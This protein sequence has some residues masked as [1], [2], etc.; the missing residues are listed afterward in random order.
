MSSS[1]INDNVFTY[2]KENQSRFVSELAKFVQFPSI[3]AKPEHAVDCQRCATWLADHLKRIGL[4][5]LEIVTTRG[6]PIVYAEGGHNPR[7]PT[8][9]IYGHY[10]VQ[11]VGHL[12]EWKSPPFQP[13]VRGDNLYGRGA[14][15]DKG[16]LFAHV[17]ALEAYLQTEATLPVNIRC[18]FEGEEEIGSP[19]LPDFLTRYHRDL[20]IDVALISDMSILAPDRPAITYASR[21]ALSFELELTGPLRDVHSGIF[22]GAIHNPLQV[23]CEIIAQLHDSSGRI[24]IPGF[25]DRV[26]MWRKNERG[27]M[28]ENGPADSE[29]LR[30]ALVGRGWGEPQFT[31]YERTTIRPALTVSGIVGGYQGMG[32]KA[33]IPARAMAKLGFRL[34]PD[35]HPKEIEKLVRRYVSGL[36]PP[37]VRTT[38]R[39]QLAA[40]PAL[41][42]RGHPAIQAAAVAYRRGFGWP[43]VFLRSGG[44]I[45]V[46]NMLNQSLGIP[47][48]LMGFALPNDQMHGPNEKF[49]LPN[50]FNGITTSICFLSEVGLRLRS[51]RR[52]AKPHSQSGISAS[53]GV[54]P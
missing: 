11:P 8:V 16:Q 25:Y 49:H 34:V 19:N 21:R 45:P 24:A 36:T 15:D 18:I 42:D 31:L 13:S 22:G 41:I 35:Q 54:L 50:F 10:D 9:L 47:V 29:I 28:A 48:V 27:F 30:N 2:V 7:R 37:T 26:R 43:P 3:S 6:H 46:V 17:K 52:V 32:P 40:Q 4:N 38:I 14:S 33:V 44:T 12:A 20:N 23:L 51:V 1:V 5:R 53:L 39:K